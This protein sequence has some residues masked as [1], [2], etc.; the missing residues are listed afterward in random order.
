MSLGSS[1]PFG[2]KSGGLGRELLIVYAAEAG[3]HLM[4]IKYI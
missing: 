2:V 4:T 3:L 1:G